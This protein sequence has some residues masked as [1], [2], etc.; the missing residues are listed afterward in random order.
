[1]NNAE[2]LVDGKV[3]IILALL[4]LVLLAILEVARVSVGPRWQALAQALTV[5]VTPLL[6]IY[7]A[8]VIILIIRA[9]K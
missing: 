5:A 2:F 1:M 4:L 8:T 7:V 6:V 9:F 3:G